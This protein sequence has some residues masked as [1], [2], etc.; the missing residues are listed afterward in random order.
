MDWYLGLW[1]SILPFPV[2]IAAGALLAIASNRNRHIKSRWQFPAQHRSAVSPTAVPSP[3]SF[4]VESTTSTA[5]SPSSDTAEPRLPDF[6]VQP[7][8]VPTPPISFEIQKSD[9]IEPH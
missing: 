4:S 2:L 5:S 1:D 7:K 8:Q 6:L 9:S 3:P